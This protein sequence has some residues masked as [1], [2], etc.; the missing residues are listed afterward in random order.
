MTQQTYGIRIKNFEAGSV[1]ECNNGARSS[2]RYTN[3]VL[4]NS[5]FLDFLL[6]NGLK[7][8][9]GTMTRDIIGLDFK[10]SSRSYDEEIA[11]LQKTKKKYETLNQPDTVA[12]IQE[13]I[14]DAEQNPERYIK[15]RKEEIRTE[16]Y[17]NG[18][19][20]TYITRKKNG[21]IKKT[22]TIHYKMLFRSVGKAK[23][24]SCMF[25][26]D[27][28]YKRTLEYLRMGI[29]LPKHNAPIVEISAYSPLI[30]SSIIGSICI[31]PED[32]LIIKDIDSFFETNVISI[33]TDENKH[34]VAKNIQNL[35]LKNTMFDGQ[36][37]IDTSVFPSWGDGYVLLRQH[38][39][40][41]AAF[42]TNIQQFFKD[43]YKEKY[44]FAQITDMFGNKHFAKDIKLITTENAMKWLK[45]GVSYEIWCE[46]VHENDNHFGVVKTAHK[47]KL[48]EVQRMSY[49]M[50]NALSQEIMPNVMAK[51][52]E[53]IDALKNNDETFLDYLQKNQTFVNDYEVL[54]A[55]V[56]QNPEFLR[57]SYFRERRREIIR[58]YVLNFKSGH[59]NQ[60]G[61]N[62]VMVGS[63]YA[64][65]LASVGEDVEKDD[66]LVPETGTIQCYTER[67]ND[68][69]YLAEF[70]SP[71]NSKSNLGYLHNN[72]KS[73]I[74]QKYF[75]FGQQIIAVNVRHTDIEDRNNGSDFDS[76]SI[77]VTDQEDIVAY[78]KFCY[79]HYP[80]IVNNIPKETK[81]YDNTPENFALM[82][83]NL[84]ASQTDIGES[85][86]L[87]QI[88]LTYSYNFSEQKYQDY[89]NILSVIA[90][91]SIDSSKR[92]FDIDIG[93]E[94]K[95]IKK[96]MEVAT[97][98]FPMFWGI[99]KKEFNRNRINYDLSCPM[100]TLCQQ[101][102]QNARTPKN[103]LPMA[104]FFQKFKLNEDRR[105]CKKV[106][107]LIQ[108]YSLDL[109]NL[110]YLTDNDQFFMLQEDFENMIE[111]IKQIYISKNYL[112]LMSWLVDRAFNITAEQKAKQAKNL[113]QTRLNKNRSL[114]LKTLYKIN[115][116]ALLA[117]FFA[118]NE[119]K[120]A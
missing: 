55:L 11:H 116:S 14:E 42:H 25:I 24:G 99:V 82:D 40:K 30:A 26:C 23:K 2:Y 13:L 6:Q 101:K 44:I 19:N 48:G 1:F 50:V 22:E 76:D 70:R 71:F 96:D 34:C 3:A 53:Y 81:T 84:A 46:K 115:P 29:K 7:I 10:Q 67:F 32:I 66:T 105:K 78:A 38:F 80:T 95:R 102:F 17:K 39:C 20:I 63:P 45:M 60:N 97:H 41:M 65:L 56:N 118:K 77:Y 64:M 58:T 108:K 117:V 106:E 93:E 68:D 4:S 74:W 54:V 100:N 94:I 16:F 57:S 104:Y 36:A 37:L 109:Y 21:E 110:S 89:V 31:P 86:N 61:D 43:Y 98:G 75:N 12:K 5:L 8:W 107:D 87:A 69:V 59:V 112:G 52:I 28:L 120:I 83:N 85:S 91:I 27:R 113:T 103:T 111:D 72:R 62:L 15:A 47:S 49:Q 33:E 90:Q 79:A 114:L 88:A 92:R 73:E 119:E 51:S 9:K 18:V 35:Q